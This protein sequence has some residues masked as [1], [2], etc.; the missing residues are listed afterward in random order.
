M[1]KVKNRSL[2][3]SRNYWFLQGI[4]AQLLILFVNRS[5]RKEL[6]GFFGQKLKPKAVTTMRGQQLILAAT[7]EQYFAELQKSWQ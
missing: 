6:F 2:R 3:K 4:T 5:L 7:G 1:K